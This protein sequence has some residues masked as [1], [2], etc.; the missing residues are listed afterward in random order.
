MSQTTFPTPILVLADGSRPARRAVVMAGEI[1]RA[2]GSP[3]HV[4]TVAMVS[5]YVYPDVLS[6]AQVERIRAEA[7]ERLDGDIEGARAE[8]IEIADTHLRM[9]RVDGEILKLA[10]EL[11]AGLVVVGN[12]SAD[13]MRRILLGDNAESVVRHAHCP[14][15]VVREE[16]EP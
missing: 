5:R 7:Q 15:L 2:T 9:G 4:A 6:D 3:L 16:H 14:V 1:A 10:E 8:G 12:R 13:A 11:G